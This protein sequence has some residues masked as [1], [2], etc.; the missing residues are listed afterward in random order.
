MIKKDSIFASGGQKDATKTE[1]DFRAG[2]I[3]NTV[4][5][6]EDVNQYGYQADRDLWVVCKEINNLLESYGISLPSENDYEENA[7]YRLTD[8][9]K[10]KV[11]GAYLLTGV[12]RSGYTT[13]PTQVGAAINFPQMKIVFNKEVFYGTTRASLQET[14]L[15][16][17]TLQ[18]TS[19]WETGVHFIYAQTVAGSNI[20]TLGHQTSPVLSSEGA[21]KCM[22]G[23]VY[24]VDGNFQ[25]GTWKF[26]PWLQITSPETRESPYASTKGGFIAPYR[27]LELQMGALEIMAEGLNF[28]ND[29]FAPNIIQVAA[30]TP[31]TYKYLR[32]GYN[33]SEADVSEID[34][35]HLYNLTDNTWDDISDLAALDTPRY[36]V[37]VPCI[38]PAGQTLMIPA[39]SKKTDAGYTSVFT[40][41]ADA[42]AA[43]FSLEYNLGKTDERAIFLGQSIIVKVGATDFS[44]PEQF[45]TVGM[46]PQA[47]AGFSSAAGQTGGS[48][49]VYTPMPEIVWTTSSVTL[50]N[51]ASN[52]LTPTDITV[53]VTIT[54]PGVKTGQTN[55]CMVKYTHVEGTQGITW[56]TTVIWWT[57]EPTLKAGSTY[58]FMLDYV[59]GAWY[60]GFLV[61]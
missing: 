23:S 2:M 13:A 53:P 32:L 49:G 56:P 15:T 30:K 14:T 40:S 60:C 8:L 58:M 55:Q 43:I 61:K 21:T 16:A 35:L 47:L 38:T 51:N 46:I 36:I 52:V 11:S 39:M 12:D 3:P 24:V 45:M 18:A 17:Q 41:Q 42:S 9:F 50:Q 59:N 6:A 48:K 29:A 26:Q 5:M 44:D 27:G 34:T 33:P 37:I 28:E 25:P 57:E 4:A 19:A 20:S 31:F 22:L 1:S 54:L 10:N 7:Q